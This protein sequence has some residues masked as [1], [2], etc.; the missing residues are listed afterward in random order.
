M[1]H[2][3]FRSEHSLEKRLNEVNKMLLRYPDRV[4]VLISTVNDE[5]KIEKHKYLVPKD[6]TLSQFIHILRKSNPNKLSKNEALFYL[7]GDK[8][9]IPKQSSLISELYHYHKSEDNYLL[10]VIQKENTF[11]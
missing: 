10:I 11:G 4:P 6:I 1:F 5:V 7:I 9:I 2:T 3:Q 8:G